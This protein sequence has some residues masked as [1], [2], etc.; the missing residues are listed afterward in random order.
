MA[1]R[2]LGNSLIANGLFDG[3]LDYR[4]MEK[5]TAVLVRLAVRV[6]PRRWEE[7]LPPP[8][9]RG[10][11]VFTSQSVW[12]FDE[13]GTLQLHTRLWTWYLKMT[14]LA[15]RVFLVGMGSEVSR[16]GRSATGQ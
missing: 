1:G 11:S 4:L 9:G 16:G 13:S 5:V 8:G 2:G 6:D 12:Q 7:P 15:Y 14:G 10:A 3:A